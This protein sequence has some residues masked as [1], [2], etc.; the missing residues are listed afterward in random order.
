MIKKV[1]RFLT[2]DC[3]SLSRRDFLTTSATVAGGLAIMPIGSSS[4]R[5][6]AS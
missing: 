4:G 5:C 3:V 2:A 1:R 6:G